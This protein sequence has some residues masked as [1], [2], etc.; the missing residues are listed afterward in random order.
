MLPKTRFIVE[1]SRPIMPLPRIV[2]SE[3]CMKVLNGG[4]A[5]IPA[6]M[7]TLMTAVMIKSIR[8]SLGRRAMARA[9]ITRRKRAAKELFIVGL[10][11]RNAEVLVTMKIP[12]IAAMPRFIREHSGRTAMAYVL[13]PSRRTAAMVTSMQEISGRIVMAHA[14]IH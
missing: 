14:F 13:I 4:N 6:T 12:T 7:K 10:T 3:R 1:L 5:E 2:A 11:G 9:M 8:E